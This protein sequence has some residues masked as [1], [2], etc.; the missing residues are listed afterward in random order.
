MSKSSDPV[1]IYFIYADNCSH[2]KD[3][4]KTINQSVEK[5]RDIPCKILK[6]KYDTQVAVSIAINKDIDDLPGIV[7]KD[8]VFQG[9]NY[10]ESKITEAIKKAAIVEGK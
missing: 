9:D 2:C 4:E 1:Q 8:S 7:I 5:C 6:F 3:A 10:S